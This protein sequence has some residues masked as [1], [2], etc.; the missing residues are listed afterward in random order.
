MM[1]RIE[2]ETMRPVA[3]RQRD[4]VYVVLRRENGVPIAVDEQVR[5]PTRDAAIDAARRQLAESEQW[6]EFGTVLAGEL[7]WEARDDPDAA[8]VAAFVAELKASFADAGVAVDDDDDELRAAARR[9]I[10]VSREQPGD[11]LPA[12]VDPEEG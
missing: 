7:K 4:P 11:T 1:T 9:A 5:A 12:A 3:G 6:G 8:L 2:D 10:K